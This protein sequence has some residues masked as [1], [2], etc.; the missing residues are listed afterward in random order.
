MR[1]LAFVLAIIIVF[2][3]C[4]MPQ[5]WD[6]HMQVKKMDIRVKTDAFTATTFIEMEFYNPTDKEMEG[7]YNFELGPGQAITAFQ[8]DLFG[9]FRDGS[10]EEKWK[11]RNAYNTIVGKRVDPALLQMDSYN[12]YS[13]RI[14]PVPAK[15]SRKI[16]MTIQQLLVI[17][18]DKT[19]YELP[20]KINDIIEQL[21]V[22]AK[23]TGASGFPSVIKGLLTDQVFY[24]KN[25][26]YELKWTAQEKKADRPLSFS[27]PL[28][29]QQPSLCVK[30]IN[31]KTFFALRLKPKVQM[32]YNIHPSKVVVFWDVSATGRT[33]NTVK[34]IAFLKQYVAVSKISQLTIITFNQRIQ[35]TAIFYT[36]GNFNSRW[37]E[38]LQAFKYEGATQFGALDF[39]TVNA[40]AILIFS[41]G[42][43]S[44]GENLPVP[45]KIHTYCISSAF[46]ADTAQI[47][48]IIGQSGGKLIDLHE[49]GINEAVDAAGKAENILLGLKAGDL[50]LDLTEKLSDI[51]KD[52]L[53]LSGSMPAGSQQLSLLYGNNGN[54]REEE[55]IKMSENNLCDESPVERMNMLAVFD[56]YAKGAGYWYNVLDWGK[57]EK[58]VTQSTSFIVLEKIEDYIKFNIRPPKELESKCDMNIFVRADE[59]RRNQYKKLNEFEILSSVTNVYNE[60]IKLWD[61]DQPPII[62]TE[63][64]ADGYVKNEKGITEPVKDKT[65]S[66]TTIVAAP[67]IGGAGQVQTMSEVVVTALGQTRSAKELGF[68]VSRVFANELTQAMPVNLQNGLTGKV[69]GLNVQTVNNGVFGNTRI[70]LRGIRSLTGN[71]QPMIIIDG[72]PIDLSFLSSINPGD[73]INVTILK[74]A[75]A[76]AIYGPDGVN[77][78]LVIQTK[79]GSRNS[80]SY[81]WSS[82]RLKDRED[83]DYLQEI[84]S[85]SLDDLINVYNEL[86]KTD[87]F[88]AGFYFDVAQ[89]FYRNGLK[90][91]A[92]NILFSAADISNGNCQVQLAMGY[93]LE[94]WKE[95]DEAINVYKELLSNNGNDIALY[96]NLALAYYQNGDYQQAVNT[97]YK[98]I[99]LSMDNYAFSN[100]DV[101]AMMLQEMSAVIAAHPD[102]VNLEGMNSMLIRPLNYD[103]RI[104]FDCNSKSLAN[105]ISIIEPDGKKCNYSK[106][107][108]SDGKLTA[109]YYYNNYYYQQDPVEYQL[110]NAK[111]GNYRIKVS[112][113]DYRGYY[114]ESKV[115]TVIRILT[116]KNSGKE[117]QTLEIENV[118]MDNQ[119]G[120]VEI[121]EV[122]W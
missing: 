89:Y 63:R 97:Y 85:A 50:K 11:A 39:S 26:S 7:L 71:N 58:V 76:T 99:I 101:K 117:N 5:H 112:Y 52:T 54:V 61:K 104:T 37:P 109:R 13:L 51:K 44:Y 114:Y 72:S 35:D 25:N 56:E 65:A 53:L 62:L 6:R 115:P 49:K 102:K 91:D 95:F 34:E 8:L 120:D 116:F 94:A 83:V 110:K 9:Q 14:Y 92:V 79:K 12:H 59:L 47:E 45:G 66:S 64:Q 36:A 93:I 57:Q 10:I 1:K 4:A 28:S 88:E 46:Y 108:D 17:Q 48:K 113:S 98:G 60:R 19:V 87:G 15:D 16:T 22:E 77:G 30:T 67:E 73:I 118:I 21:D 20:L 80:Y 18:G 33:R 42:R 121:G 103:L 82:Y 105:S 100:Q 24:Q 55:I 69:S 70:T 41:D 90:K 3:N 27:V 107:Q 122:K 119:Y 96:R 38:Y 86:R 81:Y 31:E 32:E 74:G 40:D 68:S 111:K 43:N 29:L 84:K 106:P 2:G 23:V 75:S 78:A